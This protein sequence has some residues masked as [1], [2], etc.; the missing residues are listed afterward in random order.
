MYIPL[1]LPPICQQGFHLAGDDKAIV[2]EGV[3]KRL[4]AKAIPSSEE[5]FSLGV[6]EYE[7]E[8]STEELYKVQPMYLVAIGLISLIYG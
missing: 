3:I 6:V 4:D 8:F 5:E 2:S 7:S 1:R